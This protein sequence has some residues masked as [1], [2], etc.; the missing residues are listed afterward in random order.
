MKDFSSLI[1]KEYRKN[2]LDFNSAK[3]LYATSQSDKALKIL[4]TNEFKDTLWNLNAKFLVLKILLESKDFE[5]FDV[6][7]KAYKTYIRRQKNIGY[8]KT[9]FTNVCNA[10]MILTDAN[11]N[12]KKYQTYLFDKQTPDV[13]WFNKAI[14]D[15]VK[16]KKAPK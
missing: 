7:F 9:Y 6:Q 5:L 14:M 8:H 16:T 1:S 4:L 2:T 10:F 12:K 13:D 15:I 11:K 3:I